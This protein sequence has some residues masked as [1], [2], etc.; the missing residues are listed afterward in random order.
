MVSVMISVPNRALDCQLTLFG[1]ESGIC[2]FGE[3]DIPLSSEFVHHFGSGD[4]IWETG[5]VLDLG[6][7]LVSSAV[8]LG[9]HRWWW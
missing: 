2:H 8:F 1:P 5:E 6:S 7:G 9:L 3:S 4:T